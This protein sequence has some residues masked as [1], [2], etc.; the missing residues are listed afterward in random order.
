MYIRGPGGTPVKYSANE[1]QR[2]HG[3]IYQPCSYAAYL[4][5]AAEFSCNVVAAKLVDYI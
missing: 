5:H 3:A 4:L 2:S 1:C